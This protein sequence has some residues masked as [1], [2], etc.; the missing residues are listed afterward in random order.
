M[1]KAHEMLS[2]IFRMRRISE[3]KVR[4][5]GRVREGYAPIVSIHFH[6]V[7]MPFVQMMM[8]NAGV[9]TSSLLS[10]VKERT[11]LGSDLKWISYGEREIT[12]SLAALQLRCIVGIRLRFNHLDLHSNGNTP[13]SIF[14]YG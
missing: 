2:G 13:L 10:K 1:Q 9:R 5:R 4:E 7:S 14:P 8:A 6:S 11:E 3:Q 12:V